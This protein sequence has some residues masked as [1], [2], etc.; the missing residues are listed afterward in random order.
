MR[1][2]LLLT[3]TA[4]LAVVCLA[5]GDKVPVYHDHAMQPGDAMP[6]LPKDQLWGES[7][8]IPTR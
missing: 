5:Q 1:K 2:L 7:F 3:L 4:L 8:S 6:I